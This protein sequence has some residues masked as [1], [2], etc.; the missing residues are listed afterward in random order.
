MR[1]SISTAMALAAAIGPMLALPAAAQER[2]PKFYVYGEEDASAD[3]RTCRVS[4]AAAITAVQS[5]LRGNAIVIQTNSSDPEAV[6]DVYI[7][8]SAI[9]ISNS[10][11]NCTYN[12]EINFESFNDVSNPFTSASEFTK[13]TYCSKG[14]LMIWEKAGAQS[15]IN[16]KL[17]SYVRDCLTKYRGRNK[18]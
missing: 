11:D 5:E 1:R 7:N 15:A 17:K 6:M 14:S 3:L 18:R 12:F 4:H 2:M 9:L 13:L 8:I 16:D 10:K